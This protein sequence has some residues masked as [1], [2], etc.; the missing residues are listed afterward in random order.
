MYIYSRIYTY[1]YIYRWFSYGD[2]TKA[3]KAYYKGIQ[4]SETYLKEAPED[5]DYSPLME[6][7]VTCMNNMAACYLSMKGILTFFLFF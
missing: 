2:Y 6:V 1:A 5:E 3:K 4:I 7:Y